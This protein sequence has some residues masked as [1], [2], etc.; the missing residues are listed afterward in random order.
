MQAPIDNLAQ[1][2]L[3]VSGLAGGGYRAID[4]ATLRAL[5]A[6]SPICADTHIAAAQQQAEQYLLCCQR[7]SAGY[8]SFLN[9]FLQEYSLSSDEG[10]ALMA[11]AEALLRIPDSRTAE[12]LIRD[13]L[14][15]LDWL[16]HIGRSPSLLV[17][18]LTWG[19]LLTGKY[20]NIG[21]ASTSAISELLL[22]KLRVMGEPVI[23]AVLAQALLL[24]G[25]NF[26]LAE[27]IEAALR[28]TKKAPN[29]HAPLYS[30]DML[31]ESAVSLDD[32]D[33]YYREY[34]HA[35]EKIGREK[36]CNRLTRD[37]MVASSPHTSHCVSV[38]L[39]ALHP[40][41]ELSQASRLFDELL[42]KVKSLALLAKRFDI[43]L[44]LDAETCA[45]TEITLAIL[46]RLATDADLNNWQGLG[47]CIQA[48]QTRA[49]ALINRCITMAKTS[50]RVLA[51]R[52]VKGAYWDSEI[53]WAQQQGLATY[54]VYT[55][56]CDT[57]SSYLICAEMLLQASAT[58]DGLIYP[59]FASHN[60]LTL[61]AV[62]KRANNLNLDYTAFECQRL[63]GMGEAL[64]QEL[65]ADGI[66]SRV[67]APVGRPKTLLAYLVR[68]MLENGANSSF[69]KQQ[70]QPNISLSD[71]L[72]SPVVESSD[73]A[74][75]KI[76]QHQ[77]PI[78]K[79]IYQ[80][81]RVNSN[82]TDLWTQSARNKWQRQL[83][84]ETVWQMVMP[85]QKATAI[86]AKVT[87]PANTNEV[88][89]LLPL[90]DSKQ[91][92]CRLNTLRQDN[93]EWSYDLSLRLQT[94][95]KLAQILEAEK[96]ALALL[97]VRECGKTLADSLDEIR[98]AVDFCHYY[99]SQAAALSSGQSIEPKAR[100]IIV[101]ISPW[102]FPL[103]IFI[104]QIIAALLA[105]NRV[106]A[107]PS[108]CSSLIASF[109]A[110]LLWRAG[111][112]E[113][114]FQLVLCSGRCLAPLLADKEISGVLFTGSSV[115]AQH[116]WPLLLQNKN[117]LPLF[118]AET[119]GQN[120]MIV[121][122]TA[123]L[124]QVTLDILRSSFNSAGQRCSALRILYVQEDI[125]D[126]LIEK[127][128]GAMAE[129]RLGDPSDLE[130]DIGPVIDAVS[131]KK[132]H[133]HCDFLE[134]KNVP[135]QLIFR[136]ELPD[137]LPSGHYFAPSLYEIPAQSILAAEVFGPILHVVR[138]SEIEL[139][140]VIAAVNNS[141]Y[142]LTLGIHSRI[143]STQN[144]ICARARVGNIYINRHQVGAVVGCQPF[145]GMGLSGTG[146][147][148][149]G[150]NYLPALV[151]WQG[152][153]ITAPSFFNKL[154]LQLPA[155][156]LPL[157]PNIDSSIVVTSAAERLEALEN[158]V[159]QLKTD[160]QV[161]ARD[162]RAAALF[163]HHISD[164]Q[165]QALVLLL[166]PTELPALVGERNQLRYLARGHLLLICR[167]SL[168]LGE[169]WLQLLAALVA[170]NRVELWVPALSEAIVAT[171]LKLMQ[172]SGFNQECWRV[173]ILTESQSNVF[174]LAS[175]GVIDAIIEH[176]DGGQSVN[177]AIQL[178][179]QERLV[180]I[181]ADHFGPH[182]LA[183]FCVEQVI[184][185]DTSAFGGNIELLNRH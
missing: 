29:Q 41:F 157:E 85:K 131:L 63:H 185:T 93:T 65:T 70:Y 137:D 82:G 21:A 139:A 103:A 134:S 118:I 48:Y 39:S 26:V 30:F 14:I 122:A 40:R 5:A 74:V 160:V 149:G 148:A 7:Q 3:L 60:A 155:L 158:F 169:W 116:I 66:T 31:G 57:D 154:I 172:Q 58:S 165:R 80:P 72:A 143:E 115:S 8:N 107:K 69:V 100:G 124:E 81:L 42:P 84:Q 92:K 130:T 78:P 61:A 144:Y 145:G 56:K 168:L 101:C 18:T 178:Y 88:L 20:L 19:L 163:I 10:I 156:S 15:G 22:K 4:A 126:Q 38:K 108:S 35:I 87:N 166:E 127:L 68:R 94:T 114:V 123:L 175:S 146:P 176:P 73:F 23:H 181:L 2:G 46:S 129:L 32:A 121:D 64:Y 110:S 86:T 184:S 97:C 98:E 77:L 25:R 180:P 151:H 140:T 170:G 174:T 53:K 113:S 49:Q 162:N 179:Q 52:L 133:Q 45:C 171:G 106:L 111:F 55:H 177:A 167:D 164:L 135:A 96:Q 43:G 59:Q 11:L 141:G 34:A 47:V 9:Q 147:K 150:A 136:C 12:R 28:H 132:L 102:N 183:R 6:E 117:R 128:I 44:T 109:V 112:S 95:E 36:S 90:H 76:D 125:F 51:M 79:N 33:F 83:Q 13:K 159:C 105:G 67:Y 24:M 16:E 138:Y 99:G 91:L 71:L 182:Y 62:I 27:T 152:E 119:G 153:S 1:S 37:Q 104:G 120:A 161:L 142:G 17:N 89:A 54:P 50:R 75:K 173:R